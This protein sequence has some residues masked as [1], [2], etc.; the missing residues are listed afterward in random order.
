MLRAPEH[1]GWYLGIACGFASLAF[2]QSAATLLLA[3]DQE[4]LGGCVK[5]ITDATDC[6]QD[7]G[8][9][10]NGLDL[11]TQPAHMYVESSDITIILGVPNL[12]QDKLVC[13]HL[14]GSGHEES[15]EQELLGR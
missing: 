15:E 9:V 2:E 10:R 4:P 7:L 14:T 8:L 6:T 5:T 11:A 12:S 3:G 1:S 13:Q